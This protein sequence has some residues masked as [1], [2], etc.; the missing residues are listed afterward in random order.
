M[1]GS[2]PFQPYAK[3]ATGSLYF[4]DIGFENITADYLIF[5]GNT[6]IQQDTTSIEINNV[7]ISN[8]SVSY[9]FFIQSSTARVSNVTMIST[10][11]DD[12]VYLSIYRDVEMNNWIVKSCT[13]A[14]TFL[15]SSAHSTTL[16]DVNVASISS[17]TSS[18]ADYLFFFSDGRAYIYN[19]T[20]DDINYFSEAIRTQQ[21]AYLSSVSCTNSQIEYFVFSSS[22]LLYLNDVSI[23]DS[24]FTSSVFYASY[25]TSF[26][27]IDNLSVYRIQA[28][29]SFFTLFGSNANVEILNSNL[30]LVQAPI[31]FSFQVS[32]LVVENCFFSSCEIY[33]AITGGTPAIFFV[34]P[35]ESTSS[36][37]ISRCNF[38][39]NES[40]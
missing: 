30:T 40:M 11:A 27:S 32:N 15:Q 4:E 34:V 37:I 25:T 39:H 23:E 20:F 16:R 21:P 10:T 8:C 18:P 13:V 12:A 31:V 24:T 36:A 33:S 29:G 14:S 6:L 3:T 5:S 9:V 22:S 28:Q 1:V 7:I 17:A 35:L 26:V 2:T 19:S 38:T